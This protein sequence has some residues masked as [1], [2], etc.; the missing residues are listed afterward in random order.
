MDKNNIT[1]REMVE[2]TGMSSRT[3]QRAVKD[4]TIDTCELGTLARIGAALGVKTKR[5]YDEVEEPPAGGKN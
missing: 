1:V 4:E 5:L 3:I 2:K